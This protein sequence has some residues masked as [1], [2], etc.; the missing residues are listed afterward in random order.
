MGKRKAEL[1]EALKASSVEVE[2]DIIEDFEKMKVRE[3]RD[4][5]KELGLS[6]YGTKAEMITR[7][8]SFN[9][10]DDFIPVALNLSKKRKEI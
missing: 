3:L 1:I 7:F 9:D 2:S 10:E 8:Q 4:K 5:C 6:I